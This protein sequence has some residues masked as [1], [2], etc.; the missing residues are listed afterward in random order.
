MK[1]TFGR[2]T[3][4]YRLEKLVE[5]NPTARRKISTLLSNYTEHVQKIIS[6]KDPSTVNLCLELLRDYTLRRIDIKR[7]LSEDIRSYAKNVVI[8]R[9][10]VYIQNF[11]FL[12]SILEQ[13]NKEMKL[14]VSK[15]S[16]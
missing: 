7:N 16:V 3:A 5:S 14:T 6:I 9:H 15:K 2:T 4:A 10:R 11:N 12:I 1:F 8:S 13:Y